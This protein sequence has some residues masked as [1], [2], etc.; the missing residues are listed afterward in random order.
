MA[1]EAPRKESAHEG[2]QRGKSAFNAYHDV[3]EDYDES[4]VA[5]FT[6]KCQQ[7][8]SDQAKWWLNCFWEEGAK[9]E[10]ENIWKY[11]QLIVSLDLEKKEKGCQL[12]QFG[13]QQFLEKLGE[14]L[15]GQ[16]LRAQ[17]DIRKEKHHVSLLEYLIFKYGNSADTLVNKPQGG[18]DMGP[19]INA[20]SVKLEEMQESMAKLKAQLEELTIKLEEQKKAE[21]AL[22]AAEAEQQAALD[23]LRAEKEAH[24]KKLDDLEKLST[25]DSLS[26][27]KRNKAANELQQLKSEDPLPVRKAEITQEAALRK[28]AKQKKIASEKT[29]AT[30]AQK[31]EVEKAEEEGQA[32]VDECVEEIEE[33]KKCGGETFGTFWWMEREIEEAQKYLPK[34]KLKNIATAVSALKV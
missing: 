28:V 13:A 18:G 32:K 5:K 2:R 16:A 31:L 21:E 1:E 17:V 20:A 6:E 30:E 19:K 26:T 14:T 34:H 29:A 27:V 10:A 7:A 4:V 24:Q 15:T 23:A 9:E 12:D 11:C 33:L 25:D 22:A 8:Y 3:K